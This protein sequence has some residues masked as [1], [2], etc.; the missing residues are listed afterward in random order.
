MYS[1]FHNWSDEEFKHSHNKKPF[2]FE[3]GKTYTGSIAS[4]DGVTITILEPGI[5]NMFAHHLAN[6]EMRKAKVAPGRKDVYEEYKSRAIAEQHT[7][8]VV[9]VEDEPKPAKKKA[10]A[11]KAP[12]KV[13]EPKEVKDE[14]EFEAVK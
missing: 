8:E 3:A 7:E 13:E 4:G 1:V 5:V 11:K 9:I 10:V 2:T 12:T 6:R 14:E